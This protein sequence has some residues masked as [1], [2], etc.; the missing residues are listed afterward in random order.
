MKKPLGLGVSG[1]GAIAIQAVFMHASEPDGQNMVRLAAVCDPV[2]GRAKDMAEK[3]NIPHYYTSYV[4]M[5]ADPEVD[6]VTLCS[7]IGLHY[8]QG[9]QAIRAGKHVHFNKTMALS[10]QEATE[11]IEEAKKA[12]VR[13]V[14]SPGQML[15]P[16]LRKI[17]KAVLTGEIGIPSWTIGGSEGVLYYHVDEPI[18]ET[19]EGKPKIVPAWYYKKPAGGPQW[20]CTVYA[21]VAM[22]GIFGPAKRVTAFSGQRVPSYQFGDQTITS[23]VDDSTMIILDF[24][25]AFYGV[26]Y[27]SLKGDFGNGN[28]F[29]PIV[30]GTKGKVMDGKIND[31]PLYTR[32]TMIQA[33]RGAMGLPHLNDHQATLPQP[34][35]FEDILQ[36]ADWVL[37]GTPSVVTAEHAR[38]VIE[39]FEA[40]YRS[41][42]TGQAVELTT[43]FDPIPLE[44]L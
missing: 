26:L 19:G 35:V 3:Y 11:L 5:L 20:D 21:L 8:E 27:S 32:D 40:G 4:E 15:S 29:T 36:L 38:H 31:E 43:T 30:F 24:G 41:A 39:I 44:E 2:P 12:D 34:H 33:L 42:E 23:E 10:A 18:R 37:T 6:L 13:L 16:A 25:D 22:T 7:P 9:L 1:C 14:A 17:R 28:G